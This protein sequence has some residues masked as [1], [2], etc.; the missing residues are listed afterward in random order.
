HSAAPACSRT[1][2]RIHRSVAVSG[3]FTSIVICMFYLSV[4]PI[5]RETWPTPQPVHSGVGIHLVERSLLNECHD[6]GQNRARTFS[7][8]ACFRNGRFVLG[9]WVDFLC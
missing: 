2:F 5:I 3:L 7:I 8:V 4:F 9:Q 6:L 1:F